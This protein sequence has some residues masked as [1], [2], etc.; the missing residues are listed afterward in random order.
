M[1]NFVVIILI[2]IFASACVNEQIKTKVSDN[3]EVYAEKKSSDYSNPALI[4][5]V[6]FMTFMQSLKKVG[7]YDNLINFTSSKSIDKFGKE[8]VMDFYVNKF[9]NM[10]KL[11]LKSIVDNEDGTKTMNYINLVVATKSFVSVKVTIEND[12]CK[13]IIENTGENLLN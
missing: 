10:S 4:F 9:T 8:A 3:K 12:S 11:E 13:L 2:S 1:K 6:D 7:D 5:G